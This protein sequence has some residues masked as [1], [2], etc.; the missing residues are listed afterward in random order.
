MHKS[1]TRAISLLVLLLAISIALPVVAQSGLTL[2]LSDPDL[3]TF[4]KVTLYMDAYDPQG[5]FIPDLNLRS[6]RLF[7][8]GQERIVNE[9]IPIEPGL[10]AI[11]AINLSST[12][13]NRSVAGD[14]RF[15][16]IYA[17]LLNWINGLPGSAAPDLFSLTTNE[18]ILAERVAERG[19]FTLTLQGYQPNL[20]NFEPNLDS[21]INALNL[22]G[23]SKPIPTGKQAIFYITPLMT[24]ADLPRL[25]EL[26][27]SAARLNVPVNVWFVAPDASAN[28][29]TASALT[30]L[31]SQTGG[32]YYHYTETAS[33]PNPESFLGPL[34]NTYR[35]RYTSAISQSGT[36]QVYVQVE[37]GDQQATTPEVDFNVTLA[38][39]IPTLINL[40]LEITRSWSQN[41]SGDMVLLPDFLTLQMSVEFPDGYPR[42]LRK[43]RLLVDGRVVAE[44][45][46]APFDYFGWLL[47][48]YQITES[49][50]VQVE[51]EDILGFTGQGLKI[52]LPINVMP[53]ATGPFAQVLEFL[54][55][56][57]WLIPVG[58]VLAGGVFILYRQRDRLRTYLEAR[59]TR[60]ELEHS[61]PLTQAIFIPE[62]GTIIPVDESA[63]VQIQPTP[64]PAG[65]QV[66]L[67]WMGKNPPPAG[68]AVIPIDKP[69]LKIGR[70]SRQCDV[71]LKVYAVEKLHSLITLSP[72]G[73]VILANR[74]QK[75]GTWVNFAPLTSS[76][77][78]LHPNDIIHI[79]KAV[80]RFEV[81]TRSRIREELDRF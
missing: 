4:P 46:Q 76:G 13:S 50:T 72:T 75:G 67:V 38:A 58:L 79:G 69:E 27:A 11:F 52:N 8:D 62:D 74:S 17:A 28:S 59:R 12:L 9:A 6:F 78:V 3:T 22:A 25:T 81:G 43:S 32:G 7:E 19:V 40:P 37:R 10:D 51:V 26:A 65:Q 21:L 29:P 71:V 63:A 36:H 45:S 48:D 34:R 77:A 24:D 53:R 73:E 33:A 66:R 47:G 16:E 20:F 15:E 55:L 80:F 49:H 2:R 39:P 57:G 61:D 41:N 70:D 1:T 44:N 30:R 18:G 56:G 68:A 14:T 64:E 54:R 5:A 42:Q 35:L 31:A 60:Q 23:K